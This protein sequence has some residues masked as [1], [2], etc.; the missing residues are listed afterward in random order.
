MARE[1][2]QESSARVELE[3]N[4]EEVELNDFVGNFISQ[5]VIGM[6]KSLRGVGEVETIRLEILREAE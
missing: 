3:I 6:V 2:N 5:T 1:S 4:G